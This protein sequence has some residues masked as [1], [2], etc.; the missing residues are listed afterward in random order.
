M[1]VRTRRVDVGQRCAHTVTHRFSS[2]LRAARHT[3]STTL[4]CGTCHRHR[5]SHSA[6][7]TFLGPETRHPCRHRLRPSAQFQCDHATRRSH[8]PSASA[9]SASG[10]RLRPPLGASLPE[11][12]SSRELP[13]RGWHPPISV[14][15]VG[16]ACGPRRGALG[17]RLRRHLPARA[18]LISPRRTHLHARAVALRRCRLAA[19]M[20][21]RLVGWRPIPLH[22]GARG[23]SSA[24]AASISG[25]WS[26]A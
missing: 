15:R 5:I 12:V 16:A 9:R 7:L 8:T 1:R 10:P 19:R 4:S 24:A 13:P 20:R 25:R 23:A 3:T 2:R 22:S 21:G 6:R 26:T 14:V 18:R 17:R 11:P